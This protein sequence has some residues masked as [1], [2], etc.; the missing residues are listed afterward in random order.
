MKRKIQVFEYQ[1]LRIEEGGITPPVFDQLVKYNELHGCKYFDVGHKKIR[2][3]NYVGVIQVGALVIEILPKADADREPE[4]NKWQLA[5]IEMLRRSGMIKL[6]SLTKASLKL[7]NANL[8]DLYIESY[9]KQTHQLVR[10]GL[11]RRYRRNQGNLRYLKGKLLLTKHLSKNLLHKERFYSEHTLYD[12]DNPFNRILKKALTILSKAGSPQH[13][14][15]A[16]ILLLHFEDVTD[17]NFD[18]KAFQRLKY[19][20]NTERYREAVQLAKLIILEYL[21]DVSYGQENVLAIL[22]DMNILFERFVFAEMRRAQRYFAEYDLNVSAQKSRLFWNGKTLRPDILAEF[23]K[24][25]STKRLI[26]DTKWK[27]LDVPTPSDVDLKQMYS[28]NLH[29]GSSKAVLIYPRV[30]CTE[31][32]SSP[33]AKGI[34]PAEFD[35]ECGLTFVDLFDSNNELRKNLGTEL[36]N[37]VVLD[38]S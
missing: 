38:S 12:G 29:F 6:E 33:F 23:Q 22:F 30:F 36:I 21:P 2:F 10:E 27:T 24:D 9:L 3:K 28:Y 18:A 5:L 34:I 26:L 32:F 19:D 20:R 8:L 7:K 14:A 35:H 11:V 25:G 1:T 37:E 17:Q 16:N 15:Q 4:V 13:A 31:S